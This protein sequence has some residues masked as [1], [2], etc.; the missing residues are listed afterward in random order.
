M[1]KYF[2]RGKRK[3]NGEWVIGHLLWYED[4]RARIT[5][6]HTD[7]YCLE[8]D[9]NVIQHITYEVIPE[10]VGQFT[11]L[12]DK[13]NI[14]IFDG[15]I[16]KLYLE[17][18]IETGVIR[19]SES[20]CRFVLEANDTSYGFDNTCIFEIIGNIEYKSEVSEDKQNG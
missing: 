10:T 20:K 3:D 7:I 15:H 8:E 16:V 17:D 5:P 12:T 1:N 2:F 11:G 18:T 6:R 14:K 4:G 13:N 9:E 19:Y